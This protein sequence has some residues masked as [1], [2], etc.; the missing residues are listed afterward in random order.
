MTLAISE[1]KLILSVDG[2]DMETFLFLPLIDGL[3]PGI[4]L[5]Q[6]LPVAHSG[7]ENDAFTLDTARRYARNGFA[8]AVPFL[9]HWWPKGADIELK[10]RESRDDRTVAD[11]QAAFKLLQQQPGVDGQSVGIV[12]HCWGGRAAWLAACHIP[13]CRALA[14][15]YGGN[16]KVGRGEGGVPP[17]KLAASMPCPV[18]GF[19]GNNDLNP[20]PSDVQD[21]DAALLTAGIKHHFFQ[22]D[23][24]GHAFQ[25][26]AS[27]ER[28]NAAASEESWNKVLAFLRENLG[29]HW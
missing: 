23:G 6:H 26:F 4:V 2:S 27:A 19:F 8:V 11:M 29:K 14:V 13:D 28:Y 16:I 24:A 3:L 21:L 9:F 12:G 5:A 10:R 7:I 18:M 25:N 22:F 17:I 1:S 20:S 15:F